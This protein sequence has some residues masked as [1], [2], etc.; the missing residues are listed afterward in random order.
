FNPYIYGK[1]T[2]VQTDQKSLLS[3]VTKKDVSNILDRYKTYIMGYD[4]DIKYVKGADNTVPDYLSRQVYN[5]NLTETTEDFSD[6][7]PKVTSYLQYPFVLGNFSNYMDEQEKEAFPD[8][9]S[10][11]RGRT[12]KYVPKLLRFMTLSRWH[13]HPLLGNHA[14]YDKGSAKFKDTF[15]WPAMD[16]DIKRVWSSCI[17]CLQ[18][19]PHGPLQATVNEKSNPVPPHAWHTI[20]IDY[21]SYGYNEQ[22]LT[23]IDDFS[24]FVRLH[25]TTNQTAQTTVDCLKNTFYLLGFPTVIRTD[26]GPAFSSEVFQKFC[27]TFGIQHSVIT[28]HNHRGI[29]IV[30]RFNRTIRESL[31]LYKEHDLQEIIMHTQ[32]A[33]NFS[34]M[35][36]QEGKPKEFILSTADKF[37]QE[38]VTNARLSGRQ[39]LLGFIKQSLAE[40]PTEKDPVLLPN[41]TIVFKKNSTAHKRDDPFTGP[42]KITE[43]IYGDTYLMVP[44]SKY[45]RPRGPPERINSRFLKIAPKEAQQPPKIDDTRGDR[46]SRGRRRGRPRRDSLFSP[47]PQEKNKATAKRGRGRPRKY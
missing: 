30:E 35:T 5:I 22:V 21:L 38:Q 14:G 19:K 16:V 33:H 9:F 15:H 34:N 37:T 36:N 26:N 45:H 7:F 2:T 29:A 17:R 12:R 40:K 44:I 11:Q 1:R 10:T 43:H 20:S 13:E 6:V 23:L 32:Y 42:Y 25:Y 4:L 31:R 24:K 27:D 3:L 18:C 39:E 28:A 8:C 46:T 47:P 41:G